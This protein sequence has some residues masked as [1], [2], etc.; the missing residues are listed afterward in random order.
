MR[1]YLAIFLCLSSPALAQ[2]DGE[3][4]G[5]STS[6]NT[7]AATIT[8]TSHP[9]ICIAGILAED[10]TGAPIVSSVTGAGLTWQHRP[11]SGGDKPIF[12]NSSNANPD[13][14][15]LEEWWAAAASNITSQTITAT[16]TATIK[17]AQIM[18][19][20]QPSS[21]PPAAPFDPNPS[22]PAGGSCTVGGFGVL[23]CSDANIYGPVFATSNPVDQI[24]AVGG[25]FNNPF[26]FNSGATTPWAQ[27]NQTQ[28]F[29]P[30]NRN[31][32]GE[33][34]N[35]CAAPTSTTYSGKVNWGGGVT[36]TAWVMFADAI[37]VTPSIPPPPAGS[38]PQVWINE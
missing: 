2:L 36:V 13:Y 32:A 35:A 28:I 20:C 6:S 21:A 7:V 15:D 17:T 37:V 11:R 12:T 10:T 16:F 18:I 33:A 22:L 38:H 30:P 5:Q 27:F 14:G 23:P 1:P 3:A 24:F 4:V 26:W 34:C 8:T 9:D 31:Q 19:F 29:G 25:N